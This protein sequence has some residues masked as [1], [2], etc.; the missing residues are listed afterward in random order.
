[1]ATALVKSGDA[2]FFSFVNCQRWDIIPKIN[3]L[4]AGTAK[5]LERS[6]HMDFHKISGSPGKLLLI[7][8][9]PVPL[10]MGV[11]DPHLGR[12]LSRAG[13]VGKKIVGA[14]ISQHLAAVSREFDS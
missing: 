9:F 8:Q 6:L 11:C 2:P 3:I 5:E 1:M 12:H 7:R 14:C 10:H 4:F 13:L